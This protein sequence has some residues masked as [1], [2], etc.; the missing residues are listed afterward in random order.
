LDTRC[1][2]WRTPT[3]KHREHSARVS[4]S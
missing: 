1:W 4:I 2:T 3:G